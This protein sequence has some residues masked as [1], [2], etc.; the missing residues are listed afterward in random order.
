M[1]AKKKLDSAWPEEKREIYF[2]LG[3]DLVP[4]LD[5]WA[6]GPQFIQNTPC[7]IF[8]RK[9]VG[10]LTDEELFAHPNYPKNKPI[11]IKVEESIIGIVSSSEVRKRLG[12][13]PQC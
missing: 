4:G 10:S 6:E 1:E 2:V 7:I 12:A 9:G 8:N 13:I 11:H 3:S 5:K